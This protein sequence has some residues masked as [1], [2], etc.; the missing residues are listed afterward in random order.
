M[1]RLATY[2]VRSGVDS[3]ASAAE[4]STGRSVKARGHETVLRAASLTARAANLPDKTAPSI[5]AKYF[6]LLKSPVFRRKKCDTTNYCLDQPMESEKKIIQYI[7]T[8]M[9]YNLVNKMDSK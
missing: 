4:G 3:D 6:C 9:I 2:M 1:A 7:R 5:L 8:C